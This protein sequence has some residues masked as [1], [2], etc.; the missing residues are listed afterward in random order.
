MNKKIFIQAIFL[1]SAAAGVISCGD[2][3]A[4]KLSD[5][6]M[7]D[8]GLGDAGIGSQ[9]RGQ[10]NPPTLGTQ[11]DRMGRPAVT[12]ALI[13]AFEP[14]EATRNAAKDGYNANATPSTWATMYAPQI[15]ANLPIYD[16]LDNSCG[17]QTA[18]DINA[19]A[20]MRHMPL[21]NL[22][23]DDQLVVNAA[24]ASTCDDTGY[25]AV[26]ASVMNNCGGRTPNADVID[27]SYSVLAAG[28]LSGVSDGVAQDATP[29]HSK[30]TFPFLAAP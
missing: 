9:P 8:A 26:E 28:A 2:D 5:A 6:G 14:V 3:D 15:G 24:A 27:R 20:G 12:T 19:A 18:Y 21:A 25:L 17:N 30:D 22:L 7:G 13:A 10:A 16:I 4:P 11:I 23:A 1:F 29:T